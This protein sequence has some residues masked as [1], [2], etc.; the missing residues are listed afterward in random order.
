MWVTDAPKVT[1]AR[2]VQLKKAP[3]PIWVTD[4]PKVMHAR[5]VQFWKATSPMWVTDAPKVTLAREGQFEKAPS[6]MWV[7]DSPNVMLARDEQPSKAACPMWVTDS[8]IVS[9]TSRGE[10]WKAECE[11][12]VTLEGIFTAKHPSVWMSCLVAASTSF[13]VYVTVTRDSAPKSPAASSVS[14][15]SMIELSRSSSTLRTL[16]SI[17]S[18]QGWFSRSIAFNSRTVAVITTLRVMT[19]PCKVFN[20]T[21]QDMA[22]KGQLT[23]RTWPQHCS[24]YRVV[25]W[26][27]QTYKPSEAKSNLFCA[28]F[29]LAPAT[30]CQRK[31]KNL[32]R[33]MW[34]YVDLSPLDCYCSH[35]WFHPAPCVPKQYLQCMSKNIQGRPLTSWLKNEL[36]IRRY[37]NLLTFLC[38]YLR[39]GWFSVGS[40]RI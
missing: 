14:A 2:E 29:I 18:W 1:L 10:F 3:L 35:L 9:K 8:G 26:V 31:I 19:F 32:C 11:I 28:V 16:R 21:S 17:G 4:S 25:L 40:F 20:W 39:R 24:F 23:V 15:S 27:F 12:L 6:P 33:I 5:E 36:K 22:A 7:T 34:W 37:A 30:V 38:V 13:L